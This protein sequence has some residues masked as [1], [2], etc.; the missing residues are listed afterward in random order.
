MKVTNEKVEHREAFLTIE[1][2]PAEVEESLG[3]AYSR[4]VKRVKVPGFRV[5]KAPRAV[6]ERHIGKESLFEEAL[7]SLLPKAYQQA[8]KE[9]QIAAIAQPMIEVA[10]TEPL[11]FKAKVP[12]EPEIKLGDYQ[13]IE[14]APE[15]VKATEDSDVDAVIEQLRHQ[16]ATWEPVAERAVD[17]ND[18]VIFDIESTIE[19]KPFVNQK[20]AQYQ[21][22]HDLKFPAPGFAEQLAGMKTN[23][24]KEFNLQFPADHSNQDLAGK[25]AQFKVKLTEIKQ[26]ALPEVNDEFAQQVNADFKTV[27]QL[28]EKVTAEMKLRAK[29][30]ARVDFEERV[31]DAVVDKAEVEFPPI[32]VEA[33]IHRVLD[34]Q[35]QG[36]SQG[37]E[38]YL[39]RIKK[40]EED[41]HEELRPLATKRIARSLVLS[42]IA[43]EAKIEVSDA[44]IDTEIASLTQSST[45]D[46]EEVGKMLNSAQARNSIKQTLIVRKTVQKLAEI[47]EATKQQPAETTEDSKKTKTKKKKEAK[48]E[49]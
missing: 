2:E 49:K 15:E 14:V 28:R 33:E 22:L 35:F 9:Q 17:F 3:E 25:E 16:N 29:E 1:M 24:E 23:E 11:I 47:A 30:R 13:Q 43:E 40:T 4:L 37:L 41:L 18:L 10:Q 39:S 20:A 42:K 5:G 6:L 34:Q 45:G 46:K 7:N 32:L 8:I 27:A 31:I 21:V 12:L 19:D 26:E 48:E 44:E 36:G 38:Q